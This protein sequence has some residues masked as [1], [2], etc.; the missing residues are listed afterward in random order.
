M[1]ETATAEVTETPSSPAQPAGA[2][3]A[4]ADTAPQGVTP[5]TP[6]SG[7]QDAEDARIKRANAEAA[8]YR[9]ERNQTRDEFETFK[10]TL[11]KALGYDDD[12]D[13]APDPA[14][15]AQQ[16]SE[17]DARIADLTKRSALT[18]ALHAVGAKPIARAAILG[19]G[20]LDTLDITADDY[21]A[22]VAAAVSAYVE[23]HDLKA[24]QAPAKSGTQHPGG[25][26][27]RSTT[28]PSLDDA[29]ARAFGT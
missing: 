24:G 2:P 21:P 23:K 19:D 26:G 25:T 18:E 28:P 17:R 29:V 8:K 20:V 6:D 5:E 16:I 27:G 4:P 22:Q 9:T 11:A 14:A 7:A 13:T 10:K 3:P 12:G 1:S 15:L